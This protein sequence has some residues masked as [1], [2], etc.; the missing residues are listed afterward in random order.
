[1]I[2][3]DVTWHEARQMASELLALPDRPTAI[4]AAS[5]IQAIGVLEA[6]RDAGLIVPQE[7]SV[8]GYDDIEIAEYLHL[9]TIRQPPSKQRRAHRNDRLKG[10]QRQRPS[11][12]RPSPRLWRG[13]TS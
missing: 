3:G 4:F 1:M 9:T 6:A 12:R 11:R 13:L 2:E 8:I 5:D 10:N 7:L